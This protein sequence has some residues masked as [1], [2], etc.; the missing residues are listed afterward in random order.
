MQKWLFLSC[1]WYLLVEETQNNKINIMTSIPGFYK[2]PGC[3][4]SGIQAVM[5]YNFFK[6]K[7]I[8]P[9]VVVRDI[10]SFQHCIDTVS[11]SVYATRFS[12]IDGKHTSLTIFIKRSIQIHT[13]TVTFISN[14]VPYQDRQQMEKTPILI[15][16]STELWSTFKSQ[17]LAYCQHQPH[18]I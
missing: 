6:V 8:L 1:F 5:F 2:W 3:S 14:S 15:S 17:G 9:L 13:H 12:E 18:Y 10:S 16:M 7:I 4:R 11:V